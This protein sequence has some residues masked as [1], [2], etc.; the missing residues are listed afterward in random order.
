MTKYVKSQEFKIGLIFDNKYNLTYLQNEGLKPDEYFN[1][2]KKCLT[3]FTIHSQFKKKILNKPVIE[4]S[5]HDKGNLCK[6]ITT[7]KLKSKILNSLP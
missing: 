4:T 2:Y 3:I 1:I 6:L 7:F 5:Q